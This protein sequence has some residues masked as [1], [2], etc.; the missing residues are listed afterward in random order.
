[1]AGYRE[2]I[3]KIHRTIWPRKADTTGSRGALT[4]S[5]TTE[6]DPAIGRE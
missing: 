1:M 5:R 3:R 4:A 6:L 2:G